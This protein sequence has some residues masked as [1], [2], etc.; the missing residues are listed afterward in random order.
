MTFVQNGRPNPD[1]KQTILDAHIAAAEEAFGREF[2]PTEVSVIRA[3][4]DPVAEYLAQQQQDI[5]QVLDS[6]QI[7]HAEGQALDMLASLIG[8]TR[9]TARAASLRLEFQHDTPVTRDYTIP[10][11]TRAQTEGAD[12][13]R[14]E[15]GDTGA[16]PFLDGFE[17]ESFA[18]Y[19]GD[20][21]DFTFQESTVYEGDIAL[22]C[23][24]TESQIIN[25]T[26][27]IAN[28]SRFHMRTYLEMNTAP[29]FLFGVQD[30]DNFYRLV[31]DDSTGGCRLEVIEDGSSI[32]SHEQ[33]MTIP[34]EE[35]VHIQI[36][37]M[38]GG[39]YEIN[40]FNANGDNIVSFNPSELLANV[41]YENGGF[42]IGS[43]DTN[44]TKYFDNLTT[45]RVS[46]EAQ[47]LSTGADTNVG[48]E[49]VESLSS[50]VSGVDEVTNRRAATGGRDEELDDD[51]RARAKN[52]LSDALRA[53]LPA[54]VTR[55]SGMAETRSVTVIDNDT[56]SDDVSGRPGHS[57]EAVVDVD[58]DYYEEVAEIILETKAVGDTSVGGFAGTEVTRDIELVNG[59]LK[60]ISFSVPEIVK[61]YVDVELTK[62]DQYAGDEQVRDNI[63]Q[64]TGGTLSSGGNVDGEVDAGW[65]VIYNQVAEAVMNVQGVHD[66]SNLEIGTSTDP[67][68]TSNV[69]I[70]NTE[71]PNADAT[72]GSISVTSNDLF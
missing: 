27:D 3:F 66:Y 45:S 56:N 26:E 42:G 10:S 37:W 65:D 43:E 9:E 48:S 46:I 44:G 72:D 52:E 62:T 2:T 31:L 39:E 63:V 51:F 28:G 19:T 1:D 64:Y 6:A 11:G 34:T 40:V 47:A 50:S 21:G 15:T 24:S 67:T 13:I 55:L 17:E 14:F 33:P 70:A 29:A 7:D 5:A 36:D 22:E 20:T 8:I 18:N 4:Y 58:S 57:F 69:V 68:G 32:G 25:L 49:S 41:T 61:I 12:A 30:E 54:L 60:E 35:W 59:Q 38:F 71:M 53:T 23:G 16:L